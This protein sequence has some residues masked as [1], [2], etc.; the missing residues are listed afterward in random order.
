MADRGQSEQKQL[1]RNFFHPSDAN[2]YKTPAASWP[3]IMMRRRRK[4]TGKM[5]HMILIRI[6][7]E[8]PIKHRIIS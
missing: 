6:W 4:T 5:K 8:W 7:T 1:N 2:P 3:Q